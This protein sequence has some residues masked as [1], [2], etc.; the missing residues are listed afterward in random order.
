[1]DQTRRATNEARVP[2]NVEVLDKPLRT[3]APGPASGSG[4]L[5]TAPVARPMRSVT[6]YEAPSGEEGGCG[7]L[8]G[9][10]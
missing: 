4:T 1:L 7:A 8:R 3:A 9:S 2:R 10:G 6:Y 5:K